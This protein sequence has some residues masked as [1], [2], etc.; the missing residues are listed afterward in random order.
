MTAFSSS[1]PAEEQGKSSSTKKASDWLTGLRWQGGRET[2]TE[3]QLP[4][5][6]A[7]PMGPDSAKKQKHKYERYLKASM[8]YVILF[9]QPQ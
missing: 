7:N 9:F 4:E 1:P 5:E 2:E 3:R 6:S 8:Q